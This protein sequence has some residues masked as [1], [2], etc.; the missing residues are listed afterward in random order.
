ML[1]NGTILHGYQFLDSPWGCASGWSVWAPG[2]WRHLSENGVLAV[3]I[4]NKHLDLT[5]VVV[6]GAEEMNAQ[7][8]LISHDG[9]GKEIYNVDSDCILVTSN[10]EMLAQPDVVRSGRVL[11]GKYPHAPLWTDGFSNLW[12]VL[13]WGRG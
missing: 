9:V 7:S 13:Q 10:P 6:R 3:H 8:V 4:T 5:P 1:V 2:S 11:T 12:Q